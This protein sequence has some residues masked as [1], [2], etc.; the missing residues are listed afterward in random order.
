MMAAIG[1][2]GSASLSGSGLEQISNLVI[3]FP[4]ICVSAVGTTILGC[5]VG[6]QLLPVTGYRYLWAKEATYT[7]AL[8]ILTAFMLLFCSFA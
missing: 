8:N 7:L 3:L 4:A 5:I 6:C 1:T 2:G